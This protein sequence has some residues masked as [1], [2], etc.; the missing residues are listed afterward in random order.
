V[1]VTVCQSSTHPNRRTTLRR[2]VGWGSFHEPLRISHM[3][4]LNDERTYRAA[5]WECLIMAWDRSG[6]CSRWRWWLGSPFRVGGRLWGMYIGLSFCALILTPKTHS[7]SAKY[8]L[9]F[10]A[11]FVTLELSS[12]FR[13]GID[14]DPRLKV[15]SCS[16]RRSITHALSD[17]GTEGD[18]SR[19]RIQLPTWLIDN[20]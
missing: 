5:R 12:R 9:S 6:T 7:L 14:Q 8:M 1:T 4:A 15:V 16:R 17:G 2:R 10:M 13:Y 19:I 18:Q 11:F 20:R 3:V